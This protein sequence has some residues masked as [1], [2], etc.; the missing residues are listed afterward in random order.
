[1]NKIITKSEI[2]TFTYGFELAEKLQGGEVLA[3]YGDLGAGKTKF[4]QGLAKGLGVKGRVNSPTFNILK[5]YK[6]SSNKQI[7][8]FCHIDAYR[9]NSEKDL[10]NLGIEEFFNDA[11]TVTAIEWAEKINNIW[12]KKTIKIE[13]KHLTETTREINIL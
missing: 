9:L 11:N 6:A 1:M 2:E 5:L 4:L 7:K 10:L 13:I 3:L 8:N 12:P